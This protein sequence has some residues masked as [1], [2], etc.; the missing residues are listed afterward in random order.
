MSHTALPP[1]T[2]VVATGDAL[3]A[4]FNEEL[5]VLNAATGVYYGLEEVGARVWSLLK[6]ETTLGALCDAIASEY[7][8]EAVR[9]ERDLAD[10]L[11]ALKSVGLVEVRPDPLP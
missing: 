1:T 11:T 9:C 5:V 6:Q 10:L 8:V 2:I 4:E 7:E 3:T